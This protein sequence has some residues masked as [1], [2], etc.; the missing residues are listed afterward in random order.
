MAEEIEKAEGFEDF[1]EKQ[2]EEI[3]ALYQDHISGLK[4]ALETE[5]RAN[6][7]KEKQLKRLAELESTEEER[8]QT[9]LS[10]TERLKTE[11][12][13]AKAERE[14][15]LGELSAERVRNAVLHE[16]SQPVYG[17]KQKFAHPEL[18]YDL[19]KTRPTMDADGKVSGARAALEELAK[20]YPELLERMSTI[21]GTP[22]GAA[23]RPAKEP[24]KKPIRLP[25]W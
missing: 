23:P 14:A 25:A 1:I 13:Q 12:A 16:A 17:N 3:R 10:E 20:A 6:K 9:R 24:E 21:G 7:E 8:E 22:R 4:S 18:A 5:R 15:A 2:P 11:A 19:L